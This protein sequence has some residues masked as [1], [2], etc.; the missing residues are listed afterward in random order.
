MTA[1][2]NVAA[3]GTADGQVMGRVHSFETLGALDGP[4]LRTVVFLSGCPMRCKYCHNADALFADSGTLMSAQQVAD[5]CL[6]YRSYQKEGG[7]TLSGGE[8][9]F[10]TEFAVEILRLL[11]K[12][13]IHTVLDTSGSVYCEQALK[14]ASL[15]ILDIKHTDGEHFKDLC[16]FPMDNTLR[17]LDFLKRQKIPFWIRQVTVPSITDT[18]RNL[19]QLAR[20]SEGAQRVELKPYHTMGKYKWEKAGLRY[21]L[22]GVPDADNE[23]MKRV[24]EILEGFISGKR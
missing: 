5:K 13:R 14:L 16:G 1:E 8:P 4:G 9:L 6:K 22:E 3:S 7:V 24:N 10:Q 18:E 2:I 19:R 12:K 20:L 17:T 23:L 15:V 11:K 21:S